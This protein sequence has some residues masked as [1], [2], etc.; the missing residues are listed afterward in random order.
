MI[1]TRH[2]A[3]EIFREFNQSEALIRHAEQV[4]SVMEHFAQIA[5]DDPDLW[6]VVGLLHDLD[7]EKYPEEHCQKVRELLAA[8]DV[9][10]L[11]I[12][13]VVSHGWGLCS[14]V[15]PLSRLEKTLYA[16]DELTGLIYAASLMRP[17]KSVADM[18][19]KSVKKKLKD[20]AFAAKVDRTIIHSGAQRLG[21][22]LDDLIAATLQGLKNYELKHQA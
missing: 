5:G 13:A 15:E 1:P 9:D 6:W 21:L 19:I 10:E 22:D 14:D 17:S 16:I 8:K 20:K 7:Y 3:Q 11:I 4:A 18:E 2:R 12:R